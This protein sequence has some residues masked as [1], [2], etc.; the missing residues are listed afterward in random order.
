MR[1]GDLFKL[2]ISKSTGHEQTGDRFGVVLQ[3][4]ALLGGSTV[5]VAPTSRSAK[6]ASYRPEISI[7]GDKPRVLVEQLTAVDATRLGDYAGLLTHE[8][9]WDVDCAL[10]TVLD[11]SGVR[12]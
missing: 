9:L 7:N 11:I 3:A 4:D 6:P 1:R 2:K 5:I 12:F 8:E 10:L